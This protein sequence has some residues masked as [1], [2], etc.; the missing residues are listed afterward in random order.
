[1]LVSRP[2]FGACLSLS[3]VA[4]GVT[5]GILIKE[6]S[7]DASVI[8][9][10]FYRFLFSLPLLVIFALYKRRSQF[11]QINQK[12]TLV[13]RILFG[14][15]GIF[16]W[17]MSVRT[18]PLGQATAL[19]QSSVIFITLLSP[20]V[21]GERV[22]IYR[23]SAVLTGMA[24]VIMVTDP[25]SGGVSVEAFYGV[26]AAFSGA[27]LAIILR[28]LGKGDAPASVA[29]WY[30]GVGFMIVAMAMI[31]FPVHFVLYE[32]VTLYQLMGL[33]VVA[34]F[35]QIMLTS[36]YQYTEAVVVASMR[37]VQMPLS[38]LAGYF[39]FTEVMS[40][41]E[42]LGATVI[43]VSCLV[44]IWRELVRTRKPQSATDIQPG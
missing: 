11:L 8:T 29:V 15:S 22:G 1:V 12:R 16:F 2:V 20:W 41:T 31:L 18:M 34:S 44:I 19:F 43:I 27:V 30:N 25:F 28:R 4:L 13:L 21:L 7:Q 37:Y 3:T 6:V 36:S 40:S 23:W 5:T 26:A 32:G 17:F 10:L 38:G 42:I 14:F 9:T 24:G 35:F 33:G 39:L